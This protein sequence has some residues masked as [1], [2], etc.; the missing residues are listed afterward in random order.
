MDTGNAIFIEQKK[1]SNWKI[2]YKIMP[3]NRL[4]KSSFEEDIILEFNRK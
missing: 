3:S 4:Y 2:V 1:G